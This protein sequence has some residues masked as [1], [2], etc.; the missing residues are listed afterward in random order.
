MSDIEVP[1]RQEIVRRVAE[2]APLLRGHAAWNEENRRVHDES[3]EAL[4]D[5]GV[6]KLRVPARYGGFEADSATMVDVATELGRADG[7]T[8]WVASVYWIPGWMAG[9]FPDEVQDEVFARPDARVC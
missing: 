6:F 7:S 8:A 4:A 2:L 1:T 3:I 5:A 9:L